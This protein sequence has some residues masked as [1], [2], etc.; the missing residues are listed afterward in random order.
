MSKVTFS[1]PLLMNIGSVSRW[2]KYK[3]TFR[4][5]I[6]ATVCLENLFKNRLTKNKIFDNYLSYFFFQLINF[7]QK[8]K[9]NTKSQNLLYII[10]VHNKQYFSITN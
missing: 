1:S 8:L 4:S 5:V 2:N 9:I 6:M 3:I 10:V 7:K